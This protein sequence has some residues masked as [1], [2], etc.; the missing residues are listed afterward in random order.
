M[1]R[2]MNRR[3]REPRR[4]V[5]IS[6]PSVVLS[7][8]RL[9]SFANSEVPEK[10]AQWRFT[11]AYKLDSQ[12]NSRGEGD[13]GM[14][15]DNALERLTERELLKL[16]KVFSKNWLTLDGLWFTLV[17]DRYGLEAALDLDFKMWQRYALIEARRIREEMGIEGGGIEGVLKALQF[18][19]YDPSMPV[20]YSM[21]GPDQAHIWFT[22]CRPQQGRLR[23]GREEFPCKPTGFECFGNLA[24]IIDSSVKLECV[25]CPP[26]SHPPEI[27]C[28]WKLTAGKE[29]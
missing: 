5:G 16:I 29:S 18:M 27:W 20:K 15:I 6:S 14:D 8:R 21:D 13:K 7:P 1:Q 24:K 9:S 17:E 23:A 10:A 11:A 28:K 22:S 19:T 26:D 4:A 12:R 2:L 25:F 3:W